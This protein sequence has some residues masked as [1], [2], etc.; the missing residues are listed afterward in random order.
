VSVS[1][2]V[3]PLNP[4]QVRALS[5][6]LEN[7]SPKRAGTS[8]GVSERTVR[9][10]SESEAFRAE[11]RRRA[12]S[13]ADDAHVDLL[14]ASAQAVQCLRAAMTNGTPATK[15]RAARAVLELAARLSDEDLAVRLAELERREAQRWT[16]GTSRL[17]STG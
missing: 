11:Y 2:D 3:R 16:E 17:V 7:G 10:W 12:Q 1:A 14:A 6:L 5:S 8:A 4:A 15:V 9:R 13:L